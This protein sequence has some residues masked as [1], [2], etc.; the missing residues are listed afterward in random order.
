MGE[1]AF[2]LYAAIYLALGVVAM[3]ISMVINKKVIE[4]KQE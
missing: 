4:H 2:I 3:L 1:T